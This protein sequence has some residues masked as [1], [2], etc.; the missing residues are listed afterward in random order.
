MAT[1]QELDYLLD[2][3]S[4]NRKL[5]D[6]KDNPYR[7]RTGSFMVD[8][9]ASESIK[10]VQKKLAGDKFVN[11][12]AKMGWTLQSKL[13]FYPGQETAYDATRGVALLDKEEWRVRG[14]FAIEKIEPIRIE[15]PPTSV[16]KDSDQTATLVEVVKGEGMKPHN[17][18]VREEHTTVAPIKRQVRRRK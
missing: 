7:W 5:A 3:T 16:R 2:T 8:K 14:I 12:F 10:D 1:K 15:L 4:I 9:H 18:R 17:P 13:Q 6:R 11:A